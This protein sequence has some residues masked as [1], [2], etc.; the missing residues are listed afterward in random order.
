[1]WRDHFQEGAQ[2]LGN[3][4]AGAII[5]IRA[6]APIADAHVLGAHGSHPH[7]SLWGHLRLCVSDLWE[8]VSSLP[9]SVTSHFW[10]VSSED[11]S[12]QE[13]PLLL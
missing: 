1:M 6:C 9:S 7:L 10:G 2:H 11:I 13:G 8:H 3:T 5:V 12:G 4:T